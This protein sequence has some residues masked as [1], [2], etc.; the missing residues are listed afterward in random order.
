MGDQSRLFKLALESLN[1]HATHTGHQGWRLSVGGRR[2]GDAWSES[3]TR[4]YE[5]LST[6]EL[7]DVIVVELERLLDL[8]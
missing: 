3:P 4:V 7:F 8:G 6:P 5:F 1:V 2:Q